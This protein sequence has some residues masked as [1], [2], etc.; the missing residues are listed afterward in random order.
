MCGRSGNPDSPLK[1]TSEKR[2]HLALE[3][4]Y[5]YGI[6]DTYGSKEK[7]GEAIAVNR[8]IY[9]IAGTRK[10]QG[11]EVTAALSVPL[12]IFKK[13]P[14]KEKAVPVVETPVVVRETAPVVIAAEEE[15]PCYTLEEILDLV[16]AQKPIAGKTICA[17]DVINFES[18]KVS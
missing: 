9:D 7:E 17:I 2:I 15:K 12:S 11:I 14:A 10:Y 4:N 5:Q 6:T 3:A 13:A 8:A 16:V 18:G 1:I